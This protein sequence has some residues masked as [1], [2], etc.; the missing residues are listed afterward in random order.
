M[1]TRAPSR[2]PLGRTVERHGV[3]RGCN[4]V[5][6]ELIATRLGSILEHRYSQALILEV[7]E[8][9]L[10]HERSVQERLATAQRLASLSV[11]AGGVAHDLNNSLGPLVA[12][13]DVILAELDKPE[14]VTDLRL[15]VE[16]IKLAALRASQTIKDLLTHFC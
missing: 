11:L 9:T 15:D 3:E 8:K 2:P 16:S 6:Q 12:L 4:L 5:A 1:A 14:A 10:L 13:P 7:Q